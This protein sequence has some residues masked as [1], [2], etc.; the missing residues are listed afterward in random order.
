M[1]TL[2]RMGLVPVFVWVTY[3]ADPA[4]SA[5]AALI[6]ALAGVTDVVDGFIA[7]RW[8]LTTV[9]GKL[10]DPLA[11]K[12][13]VMAA[14]VMMTRL[15]RVP[16]WVVIVLLSRE[17]LVMGLRQLAAS[18]GIVMAAGQEGKWKQSLQASGIVGLCIHYVHPFHFFDWSFTVD[19]NFVGKVSIYISTFFSVTSAVGYFKEFYGLI[20]AEDAADNAPK[21]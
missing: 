14:L 2:A 10:L 9:T 5:A 11:D 19:W 18:E 8:N 6:F 12:I 16:A 15:G 1:L 4:N 21:S 13:I 7:R 3:D 17:F 20:A